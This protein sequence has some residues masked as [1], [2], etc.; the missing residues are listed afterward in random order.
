[1]TTLTN[2]QQLRAI[3]RAA[4]RFRGIIER[5]KVIEYAQALHLRNPIH[6]DRQAAIAAGFR[7]IVVPPGFLNPFTL[8]PRSAKFDTFAIDEHN[9]L[10]GEWSWEHRGLACVGD[11]LQGQSVLTDVS[12]K[13]GKRPMI[14]LVIQTT[15]ANQ[16]DEVV[17]IVKDVTLE[18]KD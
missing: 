14:V 16:K 2:K 13:Q 8:Q 10:A 6:T 15:F 9:A 17:A 3:G 5:I 12:E 11:E 18:F 4:P 1:M 7:D